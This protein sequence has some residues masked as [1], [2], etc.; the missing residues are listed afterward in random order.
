MF[1]STWT[2]VRTISVAV[3]CSAVICS[4]WMNVYLLKHF[5]D[6]TVGGLHR[7]PPKAQQEPSKASSNKRQ[8]PGI[9]LGVTPAILRARYNLSA[10]DVGAA[11]NNSQAVAQVWPSQNKL[12]KWLLSDMFTWAQ[13]LKTP[14]SPFSSWSSTTAP[15][16]WLS[17]WAC[18]A[19]AFSITLRWTESWALK[20]QE[21]LVRRP[22]WMWST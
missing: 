3:K 14:F 20:E 12:K 7:L 21:R 22:V 4:C 6:S 18:L 8:K 15:Q 1:T 11:Q 2:L 10:T 19:G 9:H 16:T 5:C 17:L 13:Y